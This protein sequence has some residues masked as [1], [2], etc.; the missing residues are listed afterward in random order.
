MLNKRD[1]L[2]KNKHWRCS[3]ESSSSIKEKKLKTYLLKNLI[4]FIISWMKMDLEELV[5]KNLV[6][7]LKYMNCGD[8]KLVRQVC[9]N[10]SQLKEKN[11]ISISGREDS[12]PV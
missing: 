1:T 7:Y 11:L 5:R 12:K 2:I 9:F 3:T 10:S 8:M 6:R 4:S